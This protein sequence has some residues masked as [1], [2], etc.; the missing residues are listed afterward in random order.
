MFGW[1]KVALINK[2]LEQ[3]V[4]ILER[5]VL[6]EGLLAKFEHPLAS[7]ASSALLNLHRREQSL[8]EQLDLQTARCN[9]LT[10]MVATV[11]QQGS[12]DSSRLV[13]FNS[14]SQEGLWEIETEKRELT[15]DN[16]TF[17]CSSRFGELLGLDQQAIASDWFARI[18]AE[19]RPDFL[20]WLSMLLRQQG[21]G[22][23][24]IRMTK[25]D[26][27]DAWFSCVASVVKSGSKSR[28]FGLLRDIQVERKRE[29]ELSKVLTRF[30]LSRELLSDGIWDM[31]IV[32]GDP[33]NPN[34]KVWW[35]QQ[36]RTLL[37]FEGEED[38]PSRQES[39]T[40]LMH[41]EEIAS[42]VD[43]LLAHLNDR[44]GKIRLD[45]TYRL[46][47]KTGQYRWFRARGET[48]RTPDGSP[49]RI[50]GSLEDVHIQHEQQHLRAA[51][52]VQRRELEDKLTELTG[53]VS[54]IRSIA[55]QTNLL[56]L[57][58]AI[59]AARAGEAGRGFAVVAD[60]VR[61][62]ATLSSIATQKAVTL[63]SGR[64]D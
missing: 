55:N 45:A 3:L 26:G 17:W 11:Q 22:Q 13:H 36:F 38:F 16:N 14:L 58:A 15:E 10:H 2:V 57:N 23:R 51:Q 43:L 62:L 20:G 59:E 60:E 19:G 29:E 35:S 40:S 32:G 18:E 12:R 28:L 25:A 41:P 49:L 39:M 56:A 8:I 27:G 63:V 21:S 53:V 42:N 64:S 24:D 34:N 48:R 9:D 50:V 47:M 33:F 1:S 31:E 52:E 6:D 30:E 54:T 46:R 5:Q 61:K 44:T 4:S 37:G 7:R